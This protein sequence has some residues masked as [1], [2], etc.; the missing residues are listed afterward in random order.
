MPQTEEPEGDQKQAAD[1]KKR[2]SRSWLWFVLYGSTVLAGLTIGSSYFTSGADRAKFW[3]E[4]LLSA[5][6]LSVVIVQTVIYRKQWRVMEQQG[7]AA[8]EQ[9]KIMGESLVIQSQ[10]YV[11]MRLTRNFR[12]VFLFALRTPE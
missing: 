10:A 8:K 11:G 6:V 3:V 12:P 2:R 4:G 9:T 1:K 7:Q 5:G